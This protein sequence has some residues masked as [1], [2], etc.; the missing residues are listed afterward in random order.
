ML[1]PSLVGQVLV[2]KEFFFFCHINCQEFSI[3]GEIV[4]YSM[5]MVACVSVGYTQMLALSDVYF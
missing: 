4:S 2:Q 3:T 5:Q 1:S